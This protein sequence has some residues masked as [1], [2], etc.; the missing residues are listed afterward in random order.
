MTQIDSSRFPELDPND[1][2]EA[3]AQFTTKLNLTGGSVGD[4]DL[5]KLMDAY[6][7]NPNIRKELNKVIS[8]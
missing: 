6:L 2:R 5:Y 3:V 7:R 1:I 4:F 8:K